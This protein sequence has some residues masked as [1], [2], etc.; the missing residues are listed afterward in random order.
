MFCDRSRRKRRPAGG[1]RRPAGGKRG[2]KLPLPPAERAPAR[3]SK[4][5]P[6]PGYF[7]SPRLKNPISAFPHDCAVTKRHEAQHN[8]SA[9][10]GK[11]AQSWG[12][13]TGRAGKEIAETVRPAGRV[14]IRQRSGEQVRA[15]EPDKSGPTRTT[16]TRAPANP[17]PK[18][19]NKQAKRHCA[20]MGSQR[21]HGE[22]SAIMGKSA[23][24]PAP[25]GYGCRLPPGVTCHPLR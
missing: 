6:R 24:S 2:S 13:A 18:I 8:D 1:K 11:S 19:N 16:C 21:N 9:N 3:D 7:H 23:Q 12:S 14:T 15:P 17:P 4:P 25:G 20:I 10:A 5:A 22:V